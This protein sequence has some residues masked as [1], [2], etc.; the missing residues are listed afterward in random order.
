MTQHD[1]MFGSES[2]VFTVK[3]GANFKNA[4][5]I[6]NSIYVS[7]RCDRMVN[8]T[9]NFDWEKE[10]LKNICPNGN[11]SWCPEPHKKPQNGS[12]LQNLTING[13]TVWSTW[14]SV[15]L[16][17]ITYSKFIKIRSKLQ[18]QQPFIVL[19]HFS[20][21]WESKSRFTSVSCVW[22]GQDPTRWAQTHVLTW[23]YD[24]QP[25]KK[26]RGSNAVSWFANWLRLSHLTYF[27]TLIYIMSK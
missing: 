15:F 4:V 22:V 25:K 1:Q 14:R 23:A 12:F 20:P 19:S 16:C 7:E 17:L 24:P 9:L 21:I 10:F 3:K 6:N 27:S 18:P 2:L 13:K 26:F 5:N 11:G 8:M